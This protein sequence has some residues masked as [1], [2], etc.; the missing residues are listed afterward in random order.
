MYYGLILWPVVWNPWR[1]IWL[2]ILVMVVVGSV[3]AIVAFLLLV[4][5]MGVSHE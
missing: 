1:S 4:Y 5:A 3:V 2:G